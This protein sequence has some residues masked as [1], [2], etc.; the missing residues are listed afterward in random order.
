MKNE[1]SIKKIRRDAEES[2][3]K[4]DYFCS[5][6]IVSSI[7]S[8]FEI[9][10]PDEMIAMASGFPIGIGKSKCV[11][12]AV[13]GGVMCLGY[14]F[15]RTTG[16][17]SKVQNTLKLANELQ[18]SFKNNHKVLCCKVLTHGMD[19]ASGEHKAQCISFTGEIAQKAAQIIVRELGLVNID[20]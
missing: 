12:G 18:E 5:E 9:P 6:A 20:K 4:G 15:G 16:G 11:C 17:D 19:M 7:K 13:S 14:F 10:M 1:V 3:R 8:N 2:F